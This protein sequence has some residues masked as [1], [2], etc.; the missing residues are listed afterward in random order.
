M[1]SLV[2]SRSPNSID[3]VTKELETSIEIARG[4]GN[5]VFE[6][7][8]CMSLAELLAD[9]G[10]RSEAIA[11]LSPVVNSFTEG[12]DMPRLMQAGCLL[13]RITAEAS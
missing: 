1:A 2:R 4:Q 6:L 10:H 13:E 7:K 12:F 5:R 8:A 3:H 11:Q 9:Q